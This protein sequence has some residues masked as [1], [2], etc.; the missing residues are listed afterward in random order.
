VSSLFKRLFGRSKI[1]Q[2][3]RRRSDVPLPPAPDPDD[4]LDWSPR[5]KPEESRREP[6]EPTYTASVPAHPSP[7]GLPAAPISEALTQFR[8]PPADPASRRPQSAL[9]RSQGGPASMPSP[10]PPQRSKLAQIRLLMADGTVVE[11]AGDPEL[12]HRIAY[13]AEN[14][15]V[16]QRLANEPAEAVEAAEPASAAPPGFP[17]RP[18]EA[19]QPDTA[20]PTFDDSAGTWGPFDGTAAALEMHAPLWPQV[21]LVFADGSEAALPRDQ[22]IFDRVS[23][24]IEN[25]LPA[26]PLA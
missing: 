17:P 18:A 22:E 15:F 13:L 20:Q 5:A 21:R 9:N 26:R 1:E 10:P 11:F 23:Y 19:E 3:P 14:L 7:S 25:L 24:V 2:I 4:L 16:P 12:E 6:A 8:T